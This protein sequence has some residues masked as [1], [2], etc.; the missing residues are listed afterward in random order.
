M[1]VSWSIEVVDMKQWA[2]KE[3]WNA[4]KRDVIVCQNVA[5]LSI[6]LLVLLWPCSQ[7]LTRHHGYG[8]GIRLDVIVDQYTINDF[9]A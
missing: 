6:T 1:A 4:Q 2:L 8:Q 5:Y 7:I 9:P 3:K